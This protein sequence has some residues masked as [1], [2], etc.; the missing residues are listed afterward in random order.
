MHEVVFKWKFSNASLL[1]N[2]SCT[3]TIAP[4]FEKFYDF[5]LLTHG[6]LLGG[7]D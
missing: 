2:R 3:T 5:L 7:Y 4:I 1:L 6:W